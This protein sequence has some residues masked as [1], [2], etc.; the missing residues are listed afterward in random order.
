MIVEDDVYGFLGRKAPSPL[1]TL[2]PEQTFYI[3]G[4]SKVL[5]PG[6]RVGYAVAPAAALDRLTAGIRASTWMSS[7]L[8]VDLVS[9]WIDDGTAAEFVRERREQAQA[10][11]KIARRIL[12]EWLKSETYD[13]QAYFHLWVRVPEQLSADAFFTLA[14]SRGI[15]VTPPQA[16]EIEEGTTRGFRI[17][18]GGVPSEAQL[19][20]G[21]EYL[22][23]LLEEPCHPPRST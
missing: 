5:A 15:I 19:Q 4:F 12:G 3:G 9:R 18:I 23:A 7:P 16:M 21:L 8:L 13:E 6:I 14:K 2:L 17:S 10:R 11:C 1:A 22:R 20:D